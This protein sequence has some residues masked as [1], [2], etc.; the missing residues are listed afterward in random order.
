[1][2]G[3]NPHKMAENRGLIADPTPPVGV[4]S[5]AV[6]RVVFT[7]KFKTPLK[8]IPQAFPHLLWAGMI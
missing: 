4:T 7:L 1:M 3:F 8:L 5:Q 2:C 6:Y